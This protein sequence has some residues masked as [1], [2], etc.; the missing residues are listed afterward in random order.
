MS[1]PADSLV[2]MRV[3]IATGD[4][5][6]LIH[7][8]YEELQC[9]EVRSSKPLRSQITLEIMLLLPLAYFHHRAVNDYAKIGR[10]SA[11]P[12]EPNFW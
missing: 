2:N 5:S 1:P 7:G 11:F 12:N 3:K 6:S 8:L 9:L 10:S 4:R